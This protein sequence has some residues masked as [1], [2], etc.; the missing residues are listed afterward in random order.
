MCQSNDST[1]ESA[2]N[3][4]QIE[5]KTI[6][7]MFLAFHYL[8]HPHNFQSRSLALNWNKFWY[9]S[10]LPTPPLCGSVVD[11][12]FIKFYVRSD[13]QSKVKVFPPEIFDLIK[14]TLNMILDSIFSCIGVVMTMVT[15][16][17]IEA[18]DLMTDESFF[19]PFSPS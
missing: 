2:I 7:K 12:Y 14:S 17:H 6:L 4:L 8:G 3:K 10:P 16:A 5:W 11:N 19:F 13:E 1:L 18:D 15:A 9:T